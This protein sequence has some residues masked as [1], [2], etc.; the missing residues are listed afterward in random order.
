MNG[1]PRSTHRPCEC[2]HKSQPSSFIARHCPRSALRC[3]R[4][5]RGRSS[6]VNPASEMPAT[7]QT[8]GTF[9]GWRRH[10]TTVPIRSVPA[11]LSS[12][13]THQGPKS[14]AFKACETDSPMRVTQIG[15]LRRSSCRTDKV[16]EM[17][18][19]LRLPA[20]THRGMTS[21][22]HPLE[23]EP[24]LRPRPTCTCSP[25]RLIRAFGRCAGKGWLQQLG[26]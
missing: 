19:A 12:H 26:S 3:D 23:L 8:R 17:S 21:G 13:G 5:A 22:K 24:A 11:H 6:S 9:H 7:V 16:D 18:G 15:N 10:R 2:G 1:A 20:T 14:N 25:Q 4:L